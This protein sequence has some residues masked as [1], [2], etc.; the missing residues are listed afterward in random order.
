MSSAQSSESAEQQDV[1]VPLFWRDW[2]K[3]EIVQKLNSEVRGFA[4]RVSTFGEPRV[5]AVFPPPSA[6]VG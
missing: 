3:L 4:D 2:D 5:V 6:A 1:R